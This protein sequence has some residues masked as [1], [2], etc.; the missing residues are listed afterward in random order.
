MD[1]GVS[2]SGEKR[3]ILIHL[4]VVS[5]DLPSNWMQGEKKNESK[6]SSWAI[7]KM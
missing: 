3:E 5:K 2:G 7:G 4:R 1:S 6:V